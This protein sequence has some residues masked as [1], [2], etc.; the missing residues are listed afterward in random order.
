MRKQLLWVLVAQAGFTA[1]L[2]I[3]RSMKAKAATLER[4]PRELEPHAGDRP[5][6]DRAP[7][8]P[9]S[10]AKRWTVPPGY[11]ALRASEITPSLR[12]AAKE[13]TSSLT[14]AK[15]GDWF[16]FELEGRRYGALRAK[17][18]FR[19]YVEKT[20]DEQA[21]DIPAPVPLPDGLTH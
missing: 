17:T 8:S 15:P 7:S 12:T 19:Y 9:S 6:E 18:T 21:E 14:D 11:R 1:A 4:Q 20:T 10:P 13:I 3:L 2:A 16:P 5:A